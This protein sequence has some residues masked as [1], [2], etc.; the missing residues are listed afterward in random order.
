MP[1][2]L[3]RYCVKLWSISIMVYYTPLSRVRYGFDSRIDRQMRRLPN[4]RAADCNSADASH[5]GFDSLSPH[6][7]VVVME[8]VDML[9][10]DSSARCGVGVQLPSTI[11]KRKDTQIGLR[12]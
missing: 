1:F 10:L 9:D 3:K 11:P 12:G 6:Q 2:G 4:G 7:N 5:W 8:L